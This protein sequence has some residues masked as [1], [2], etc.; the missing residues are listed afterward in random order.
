MKINYEN[1]YTVILKLTKILYEIKLNNCYLK[2]WKVISIPNCIS[3]YYV[4]YF[5]F[6]M[7]VI[8]DICNEFDII[9]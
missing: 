9:L 6:K 5:S 2:A 1:T 4:A 7:N 3:M 8:L